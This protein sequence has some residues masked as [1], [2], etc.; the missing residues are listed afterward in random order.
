MLTSAHSRA[1]VSP[2]PHVGEARGGGG[3]V[4]RRR[5][6]RAEAG[7]REAQAEEAA[8]RAPRVTVQRRHGRRRSADEAG[9]GG[10]DVTLGGS[11]GARGRAPEGVARGRREQCR[12]VRR[13]SGAT[14]EGGRMAVAATA[15]G[16][17]DSDGRRRLGQMISMSRQVGGGGMAT[18]AKSPGYIEEAV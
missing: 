18:N 14:R 13:T 9:A 8:R 5:W 6:G 2:R 10:D 3:S 17:G 15:T 16:G 7:R 4:R 1:D 11:N 12:A